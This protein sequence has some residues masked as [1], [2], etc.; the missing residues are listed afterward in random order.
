MW[1]TKKHN[2]LIGLIK[3]NTKCCVKSIKKINCYLQPVD[4]IVDK[5]KLNQKFQQFSQKTY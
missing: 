1:I 4:N 5:V 3:I 2:I